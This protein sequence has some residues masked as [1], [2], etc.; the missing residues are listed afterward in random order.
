MVN[1]IL[2]KNESLTNIEKLWLQDPL[3]SLDTNKNNNPNPL[4]THAS[5][6]ERLFSF[7]Y[8]LDQNP[9]LEGFF[10]PPLW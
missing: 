8:D 9:L 6:E 1:I 4:K 3:L 7:P 5:G 2:E 10:F